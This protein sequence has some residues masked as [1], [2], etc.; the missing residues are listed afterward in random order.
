MESGS[1]AGRGREY[2]SP[3][4]PGIF[5]SLRRRTGALHSFDAVDNVDAGVW[6]MLPDRFQIRFAPK[7]PGVLPE[8]EYGT[9]VTS[10]RRTPRRLRNCMIGR[11]ATYMSGAA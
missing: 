7:R 4:T 11:R 10:S 8:L 3:S 1:A 9:A 5:E 2:R 6:R